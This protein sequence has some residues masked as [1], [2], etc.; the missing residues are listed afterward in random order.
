MREQ[1][2]SVFYIHIHSYVDKSRL[3]FKGFSHVG[4]DVGNCG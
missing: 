3:R 2:V 1:G 4:V